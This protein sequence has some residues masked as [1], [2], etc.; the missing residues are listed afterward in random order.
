MYLPLQCVKSQLTYWS[1]LLHFPFSDPDEDDKN[2]LWAWKDLV[3]MLDRRAAEPIIDAIYWKHK[4]VLNTD[5]LNNCKEA[6]RGMSNNGPMELDGW[7]DILRYGT[8][9]EK[10]RSGAQKVISAVSIRDFSLSIY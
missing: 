1:H 6:V 10:K 8:E 7:Q 9:T 2:A 4:I 5:D 3:N